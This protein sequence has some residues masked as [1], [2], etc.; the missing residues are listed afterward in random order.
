MLHVSH[1]LQ[2]WLNIFGP[3]LNLP[4]LD[5]KAPLLESLPGLLSGIVELKSLAETQPYLGRSISGLL[6]AHL[7]EESEWDQGTFVTQ[8]LMERH[9]RLRDW[10]AQQILPEYMRHP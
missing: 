8:L 2:H 10:F 4:A 3:R 7:E 9:S 5:T 6:A 1:T